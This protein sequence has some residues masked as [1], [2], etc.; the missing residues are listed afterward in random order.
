MLQ[1][2]GL[3]ARRRA[4][5]LDDP[6]DLVPPIDCVYDQPSTMGKQEHVGAGAEALFIGDLP[7]AHQTLVSGRLGPNRA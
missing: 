7:V 1:P 2:G 5:I 3:R 4:V 6:A